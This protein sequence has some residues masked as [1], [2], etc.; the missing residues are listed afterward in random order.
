MIKHFDISLENRTFSLNCKDRINVFA[1]MP[2]PLKVPFQ[3]LFVPFIEQW[4]LKHD[5]LKIYWPDLMECKSENINDL[6]DSATVA[7]GL[8]DL[9]ISSSYNLIQSE[10]FRTQ[11]LNKGIFGGIPENFYPKEYPKNLIN[12]G[13]L[14]HIAFLGFSSWGIIRDTSV[15]GEIPVPKSWCELVGPEYK[16][17]LSIHG[18]HGHAGNVSILIKLLNNGGISAIRNFADN[19]KHVGHFSELIK[20]INS[21]NKERTPFVILPGSAIANI[22]STKHAEMLMMNE[23]IVGPMMLIVKQFRIEQCSDLIRFFVGSDFIKILSGN[24][25]FQARDIL[26]IE[27]QN[28]AELQLIEQGK[29]H[30]LSSELS[31]IFI[32]ELG[33]KIVN[34]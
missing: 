34:K 19:I 14:Y 12:L 8:P 9:M 32:K 27:N 29:Y 22:P 5:T 17:L 18:C 21:T 31:G 10:N 28:F 11:F 30:K 16:N 7:E 2:C 6:L 13:K 23:S 3:Q 25:F 1:A 15:K 4:N 33:A 26:G 20:S 24:A